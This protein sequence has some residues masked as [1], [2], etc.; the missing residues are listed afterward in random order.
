LPEQTY[1]VMDLGGRPFAIPSRA[2][3]A[4]KSWGELHA[5]PLGSPW[6]QGLLE[7]E[8]EVVPVIKD[9]WFEE[10]I[11]GPQE[12]LALVS[13]GGAR[14]AVPG[15]HPRLCSPDASG[16]LP[17]NA[18]GPWAA[19]LMFGQENVACLDPEKLYLELGLHKDP[20]QK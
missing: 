12:V 15:N 4:L 13:A 6:V 20:S 5:L 7:G 10:A 2:V 11:G 17:G 3:E 16:P 1:L 8:G 9:P 18:A 14:I 19:T